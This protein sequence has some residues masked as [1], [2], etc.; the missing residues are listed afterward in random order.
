MLGSILLAAY[1]RVVFTQLAQE[2]AGLLHLLS[3]GSHRVPLIGSVCAVDL[4]LKAKTVAES[5]ACS[6]W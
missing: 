1:W 5:G 3:E 6:S 4:L 2:A